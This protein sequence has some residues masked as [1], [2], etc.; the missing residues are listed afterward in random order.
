MKN[1]LRE[2][3]RRFG[4]KNLLTEEDTQVGELIIDGNLSGNT[5][6]FTRDNVSDNQAKDYL[7]EA[8][9]SAYA[10]Y[11][12][13]IDITDPANS[14][15]VLKFNEELNGKIVNLLNDKDRLA[16]FKSALA[17]KFEGRS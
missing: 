14:I 1:I 16:K 7:D 9:D 6:T 2:N 3:M 10:E 5:L 17:D 8:G 15:N 13:Q 4:T 11:E 12:V